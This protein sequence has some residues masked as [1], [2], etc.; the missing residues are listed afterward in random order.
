ME[1]GLRCSPFLAFVLAIVGDYPLGTLAVVDPIL[2]H[3]T[4]P[5]HHIR[6][7]GVKLGFCEFYLQPGACNLNAAM[8][9]IVMPSF[10]LKI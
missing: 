7:F 9:A 8:P 5:T 6:S 2:S 4:F 1:I 10:S 3:T